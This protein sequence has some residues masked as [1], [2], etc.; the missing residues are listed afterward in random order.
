MG[1]AVGKWRLACVDDN[2]EQRLGKKNEDDKVSSTYRIK[3]H[4][5]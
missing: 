5:D 4:N 1:Y 2:R 3:E